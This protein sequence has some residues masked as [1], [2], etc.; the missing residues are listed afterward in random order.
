MIMSTVRNLR[1]ILSQ[2]AIHV[3]A[4][5]QINELLIPAVTKLRNTLDAKSN[6]FKDIVK[7]G[8]THLQ[9]ATPLTLGQEFSG[10]CIAT[11]SRF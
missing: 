5:L 7:I 8:R 10:L 9:D 1:M 3:A 2:L 6:D 11:R 4:S